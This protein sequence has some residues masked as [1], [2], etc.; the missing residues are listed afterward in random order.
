MFCLARKHEFDM[1]VP[2]KK[3]RKYKVIEV[4]GKGDEIVEVYMNTHPKWLPIEEILPKKLLMRRISFLSSNGAKEMVI[5]TT[6]LNKD[7]PNCDIVHKY[8][9]RWDIEITIREVKT[10]MDINVLRGKTDDIVRKELVSA[11]I[12]YNMIRKLITQSTKETTF[13]PKTD[14]IQEFFENNKNI[15]IDRK[16]RV[17]TRWSSGRYGK[18][19][20]ENSET[21]H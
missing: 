1:I 15:L 9:T 10:I 2:G 3:V 7:I 19:E 11:F 8:F 18:V 5:Y 17:Y 16:G 20:S 12:A 14:L 4:I 21:H 6:L 13:S